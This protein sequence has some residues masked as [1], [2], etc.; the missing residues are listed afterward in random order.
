MPTLNYVRQTADTV[1]ATYVDMPVSTEVVFVDT[2]SGAKTP[3]QSNALRNGGNGSAD[4][5]ID[6][7]LPA[8]GYYL[9]AQGPGGQYLAQTVTFYI[10]RGSGG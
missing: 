7:S 10:R 1:R 3:S 2:T 6:P 9:L 8:A 5:P 4:I